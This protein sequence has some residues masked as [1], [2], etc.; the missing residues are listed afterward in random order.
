V[1]RQLSTVEEPPK[2]GRERKWPVLAVAHR[3]KIGHILL[4]LGN[5]ECTGKTE[6]F[7]KAK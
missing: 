2:V 4:P 7:G 1:R 5:S 3:A 6:F